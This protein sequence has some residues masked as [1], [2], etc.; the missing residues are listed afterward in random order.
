MSNC[1]HAPNKRTTSGP[2]HYSSAKWTWISSFMILVIVANII[3]PDSPS[4][5]DIL[6]SEQIG[7]PS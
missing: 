1:F 4:W 5:P 2:E 6:L 3:E 7:L